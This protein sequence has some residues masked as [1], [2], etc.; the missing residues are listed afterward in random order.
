MLKYHLSSLILRSAYKRT[1]KPAN[2]VRLVYG[3]WR[4]PRNGVEQVLFGCHAYVPAIILQDDSGIQS[5]F[6]RAIK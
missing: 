6:L 4:R 3:R 1:A 5:P 2:P